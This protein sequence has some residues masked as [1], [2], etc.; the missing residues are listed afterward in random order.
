[1]KKASISKIGSTK[2]RAVQAE[3]VDASITLKKMKA[4]RREVTASES[5]ARS[6]LIEFGVLSSTGKPLELTNG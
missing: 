4:Y 2:S 6:F 3:V 1:M 5:V